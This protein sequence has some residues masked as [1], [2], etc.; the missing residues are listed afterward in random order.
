MLE[1]LNKDGFKILVPRIFNFLVGTLIL[2]LIGKNWGASGSG[3]YS[4][5]LTFFVLASQMTIFGLDSLLLHHIGEGKFNNNF[6]ATLLSFHILVIAPI[7]FTLFYIFRGILNFYF[8]SNN[9]IFILLVAF[10]S[11]VVA[12]TVNVIVLPAITLS[13]SSYLIIPCFFPFAL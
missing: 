12:F 10:L 9:N 3:E 8:I 6:F 11:N 13:K 4:I 2:F 1:Y 5:I 7:I